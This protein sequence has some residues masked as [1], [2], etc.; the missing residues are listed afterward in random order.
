[1]IFEIL[2]FGILILM[3][4]LYCSSP[5]ELVKNVFLIRNWMFTFF[6]VELNRFLGGRFPVVAIPILS[7]WSFIFFYSKV[8]HKFNIFIHFGCPSWSFL[9]C[10]RITCNAHP[11][12]SLWI[13]P[14]YKVLYSTSTRRAAHAFIGQTS[15]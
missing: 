1:M 6:Y 13:H 14:Y 10:H 3:Q 8:V 15:G 5:P 4:R 2:F 11:A 7:F 12:D 9:S